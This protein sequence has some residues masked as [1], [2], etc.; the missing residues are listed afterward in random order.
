MIGRRD[1]PADQTD[2]TQWLRQAIALSGQCPRSDRSFA[3]GAILVAA[4]GN[5][6]AE[7]FSLELGVGFHA[8]ETAILKA[9]QAG[10][11]VRGAT[12]YT[13]LEPCSVRLSGKRPCV[14]H[15]VEAGIVRVVYALAE[16]P[17]FVAC[18]GDQLLRRH[19]I[20]VV[21]LPELAHLVE[22]VNAHLLM[23]GTS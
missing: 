12:I 18:K 8:E 16:P 17:L 9:R 4:D 6:L 13:S 1:P 7:G 2:H 21:R 22:E 11:D 3:V 14:D 23:R 19:G 20:H 5:E 15:I 10:L